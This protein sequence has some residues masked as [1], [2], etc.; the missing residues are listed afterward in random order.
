MPG[1]F[2]V[3]VYDPCLHEYIKCYVAKTVEDMNFTI[4]TFELAYE[5]QG[6]CVYAF[7]LIEV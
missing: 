1:K 6:F 3:I 5:D 7:K 2:I 4:D